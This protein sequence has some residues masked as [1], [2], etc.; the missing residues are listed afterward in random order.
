MTDDVEGAFDQTVERLRDQVEDGIFS[1]GAQMAVELRGERVLDVAVGETGTGV[2]MTP[3]H[4]FRVYCSIKPVTAVAIQR[5]VESGV[6]SLDEPLE[7]RLPDLRVLEGGVTLRHVMTHTAALHRPMA[8]EMELVAADRRREVIASLKRPPGWRLGVDAAYSEYVGWQ[9]LGWLIEEATGDDLRAH[10]RDVV[11]D[12]MGLSSTWI[13][14][15]R[16]EYRDVVS[17]LGINVDMR[18]KTLPML[19]ER[20][21][22]VCT[23]TNPSHG[24]YT[25][26]RD[27]ARFYSGL[28]DRL[29]VL[30]AD[31]DELDADAPDDV[32]LRAFTS[33][34][35]PR[36]YDEVLQRECTYG[37]GFMTR[38][39]EH[40]FGERCSD[41]AF[42]HSGNV[43]TSFAF[44]DPERSLTVAVVFNGLV[45]HEAAFLRRRA[46]VNTLYQDL[47]ALESPPDATER[48][49]DEAPARAARRFSLLRRRGSQHD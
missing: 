4:V 20:S 10:L 40:A 27:L 6:L 47:D 17:R 28:L 35:R 48:E 26:A 49:A 42:G 44:A 34:A 30:P 45:G 41:S 16:D 8:V 18:T 7:A 13:G 43:G 24:G 1:P 9:I 23:E 32:S 25:N 39:D 5:L 3:E 14:M 19:F 21:E 46:L 12:P 36:V 33:I 15:T 38:L 2:E 11:L 31:D 22:R 29:G 37:L